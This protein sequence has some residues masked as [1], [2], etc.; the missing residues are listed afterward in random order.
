MAIAGI[1]QTSKPL[2]NSDV[3][4]M[5]KLGIKEA[6][7]TE[8]INAHPTAFDISVQALTALKEGGVSQAVI[9]AMISASSKR[10]Q[11]SPTG[12]GPAA[13]AV[14]ERTKQPERSG[15]P[16]V[17]VE[18]VTSAGTKDASPDTVLEAIK[19]LQRNGI[20]VVTIKDKADYILQI[21]RQL[22]KKSWSKDTKVALS[23]QN[24]EVVYSNSTRS[25]GGAMGDIVEFIKKR[26][27]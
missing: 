18:E 4:G 7:I 26:H 2:T 15:P 5:V 6:S 13:P 14:V 12:A 16:A 23:N 17:F 24:G 27:E 25:I 9:E 10:S 8:A 22:G 11:P 20:R 19:T 1:A 3:A 21:I